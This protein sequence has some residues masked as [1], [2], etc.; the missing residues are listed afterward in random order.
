MEEFFKHVAFRDSGCWEWTAGTCA[1]GRYG[2]VTGKPGFRG[3]IAAHRMAYQM[4]NGVL[5][6]GE[7]VCHRCDNGICVNPAHLFA[8]TLK[9]NFDDMVAKGRSG[10]VFQKGISQAGENNAHAKLTR[11]KVLEI[12]SYHA[13]QKCTYRELAKIFGLCSKSYAWA[14]VVGHVWK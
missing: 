9:D 7:V 3:F 1:N 12:R 2:Y 6:A 8:G 10:S 13:K 5:N 14:I 11:Q 4:F